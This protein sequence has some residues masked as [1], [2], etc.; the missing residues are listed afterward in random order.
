[1]LEPLGTF[2]VKG[3]DEPVKAFVVVRLN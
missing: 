1:V 3:R 2:E